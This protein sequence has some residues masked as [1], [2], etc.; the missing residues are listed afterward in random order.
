MTLQEFIETRPQSYGAGNANLLYSSSVSGSDDTP[1]APFVLQGLTI[2]FTSQEGVNVAAA[3][4]EVEEFKFQYPTGTVTA[5][6]TGR[7]KRSEYFYFTFEEVTVNS[8]PTTIGGSGEY[9]YP[10]SEFV[11]IPYTTLTFNNNDYNPLI[12][13]SEGSKLNSKARK[14]DRFADAA[15]PTNIQA[16]ISQ[17]AAFAEIQNC[18]Y[19]KIGIINSKYNGTKATIAGPITE[20]NKQILTSRVVANAIPGNN[21]AQSYKEFQGSIHSNDAT[22]STIKAINQSDRDIA[23]IF[24]NSVITGTHPN[25]T[26]PNFP[27]SGS[28]LYEENKNKLVRLVN[29]KI[30]SIDKGQ[31]FTTNEFGG[32]ITVE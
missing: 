13:N 26:F 15:V 18:S 24:F 28:F 31:V 29:S 20:Y 21:P 8:L 1:I 4:K 9:L 23:G 3:F 22:T 7:Q 10:D 5:K 2:P 17:S 6:I 30:Y 32:V 19:T 16:I 12:N 27:S 14:V 11:F 25:K